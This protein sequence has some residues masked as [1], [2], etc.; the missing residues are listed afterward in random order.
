MVKNQNRSAWA[1]MI[2]KVKQEFI[3]LQ[4]IV[5]TQYLPSLHDTPVLNPTLKSIKRY[6]TQESPPAQTQRCTPY[7]LYF[8]PGWW[9]TLSC[10]WPSLSSPPPHPRGRTNKVKTLPSLILRTPTVKSLN[11]ISHLA[12]WL[13]FLT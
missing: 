12:T 1:C 8:L 2:P 10:S 7:S 13:M 9:G 3:R 4:A 6:S 11:C 5:L